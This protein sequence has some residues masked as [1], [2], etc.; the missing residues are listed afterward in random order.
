MEIDIFNKHGNVVDTINLCEDCEEAAMI[1]TKYNRTHNKTIMKVDLCDNCKK[2]YERY[3]KNKELKGE[4]KMM[5]LFGGMNNMFGKVA[6]GMCRVSMSGKIAIKTSSGYKTYDVNTGRLTNCDNFAF[7]IGEDFFFV[8]PT[9][10]VTKG[11]IILAG[12]KPRCVIEAAKNEIKTFSYE[13]GTI[14][15]LVPE[16]HMFMGKQ[17][18]YGKI[19][20]V[21]GNMFGKGKGMNNM[22]KYMM[23]SEMLGGK[24]GTD[25]NNML[26]MLMMM[27]GGGGIFD[28]MFDMDEDEDIE[29]EVNDEEDE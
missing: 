2:E 17:Y 4:N 6:P 21:F 20:S 11:D 24:T 19:I 28:G 5:N 16:R 10:K 9:N 14:D 22:I 12:G 13:D 26:P 7:D 25:S 8:I 18:F 27:N 1:A 15:T 23:M 29:E 3:C